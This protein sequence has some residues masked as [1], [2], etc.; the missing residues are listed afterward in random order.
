MRSSAA[1]PL[2]ASRTAL[3]ATALTSSIPAARQKAA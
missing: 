2:T 3:V 1:C